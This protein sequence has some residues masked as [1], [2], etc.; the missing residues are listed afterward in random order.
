MPAS[1]L[2]GWGGGRL[3]G[4]GGGGG[5]SGGGL[6]WDLFLPSGQEAQKQFP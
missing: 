3:G 5:G 6:G 1:G 4:A 2:R